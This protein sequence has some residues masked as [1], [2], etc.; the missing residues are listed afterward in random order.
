MTKIIQRHDTA[1]NWST[2]NPV[3]ALGE[4]GVETDTNKFKFGDGTTPYNELP[5]AAGEGG[6][7]TTITS[8]DGTTSYNKLA[9]GDGLIVDNI[10]IYAYSP[11][12]TFSNEPTDGT[13]TGGNGRYAKVLIQEYDFNTANSWE[14]QT[15]ITWGT[16]RTYAAVMGLYNNNDYHNPV[17]IYEQDKLGMFLGS[18]GSGWNIAQPSQSNLVPVSG[19]TYYIKMGFTGS[20]YYFKY[21]TTGWNDD[22]TIAQSV[23]N[24]NKVYTEGQVQFALLNG[25]L[26]VNNYYNN[27]TMY[28][29]DTA[30]ILDEVEVWRGVNII[31]GPTTLNVNPNEINTLSD[32]VN[33]N[34]ADI[35]ELKTDKQDKLTAGDGIDISL[36]NTSTTPPAIS[37]PYIFTS[38]NTTV[39]TS[40]QML[41]DGAAIHFKVSQESI[42][43][44]IAIKESAENSGVAFQV[45]DNVVYSY[46]RVGG[47]D[48]VTASSSP[49]SVTQGIYYKIKYHNSSL[50][51]L[52]YSLD[53][54]NYIAIGTWTGYG[55]NFY[56]K[57]IY[58]VAEPRHDGGGDCT[59]TK[60]EQ[61]ST[62]S[63]TVL[64][65]QT[66]PATI[67]S[68]GAVQPDGNTIKI[69]SS[70]VI[71][72]IADKL[73][74]GASINGV[75]FD[76]TKDIELPST[77][78]NT[79]LSNLTE[80]GEKHF[81]NKQQ[82]TNCLLEVP[83]RI[84]LEL[85]D[86]VLTLKAGSQV[87]IP[88]GFK[89]DG[90]TPKFDEVV[91][92]NDLTMT[93]LWGTAEKMAIFV[94]PDGTSVNMVGLARLSSGTTAPTTA[95]TRVWYDTDTNLV[96]TYSGGSYSGDNR[97]FPIAIC[98]KTSTSVDNL[99]NSIDQVF[100]GIGY[101]GY[102]IWIDKGVKGLIPDSINK[103]GTLKTIEQVNDKL[104]VRHYT[105]LSNG[106]QYLFGSSIRDIQL[107]VKQRIFIS[108]VQPTI[109]EVYERWY[110][111]RENK[112]YYHAAGGTT[113]LPSYFIIYG[114]ASVN[115][116]TITSFNPKLPFRAVDYND[117]ST[118]SGWAMTSNRYVDLTLGAS[119]SP[120][121]APD[122]GY[123]AI[124]TKVTNTNS[125][126]LSWAEHSSGGRVLCSSYQYSNGGAFIP[127][128]KGQS[129][130]FYYEG[131]VTVEQ[132][133]FIYAEG[134]V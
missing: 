41:D 87:I 95:D 39:F 16:V 3:L 28:L 91:V 56:N 9:L 107:G 99:L 110:N 82:I 35:S 58:M 97:S 113:W 119:G 121:I 46:H 36:K 112:C 30:L 13:F 102:S 132:I 106:E 104:Y 109:G 61:V 115:N 78:A 116:G 43:S 103:D 51:E 33:A 89:A 54:I 88:N 79:E 120:Y 96:K 80:A 66:K 23:D 59:V 85:N 26:T 84:K 74:P 105:A 4:M 45:R 60:L 128:A 24:T 22:F 34:E 62:T 108:D 44:F 2:I 14:F 64:T 57:D 131:H 18:T 21:N 40:N 7:G 53:G 1:V 98:T 83:Q 65:I 92:K 20:Q 71:S 12:I 37:L 10:Y 101:I 38:E 73:T 52:F 6:S 63:S 70:G 8:K 90:T 126:F 47:S 134:E 42:G 67:T 17:L 75:L 50:L 117:K 32:R 122:N 129:I 19:Q 27:S 93:A 76:G 118:A 114:T 68:I 69:S 123:F 25:F 49:V 125:S 11:Y 48:G 29:E 133:R 124:K 55:S 77:G 94:S 31:P 15:K 130:T 127:C 86:G 81:L 100:N 111:P 5:Y 72:S